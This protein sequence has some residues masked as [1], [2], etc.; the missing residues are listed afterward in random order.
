MNN[1]KG[2]DNSDAP[3]MELLQGLEEALHCTKCRI[4]VTPASMTVDIQKGVY[5]TSH[6]P[7]YF[8]N[9]NT[10]DDN[11]SPLETQST[12]EDPSFWTFISVSQRERYYELVEQTLNHILNKTKSMDPEVAVLS[13]HYQVDFHI[14]QHYLSHRGVLTFCRNADDMQQLRHWQWKMDDLD[15]IRPVNLDHVWP[16]GCKHTAWPRDKNLEMMHQTLMWKRAWLTRRKRVEE[17]R[18]RWAIIMEERRKQ[19]EMLLLKKGATITVRLYC[20]GELKDVRE[21]KRIRH[22]EPALRPRRMLQNSGL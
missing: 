2:Q 13:A 6:Y 9:N 19:R 7:P 10:R 15:N 14:R 8:R 18:A 17:V 11:I 4:N 3:D 5:I 12:P 20:R 21:L 1:A 22:S 16:R